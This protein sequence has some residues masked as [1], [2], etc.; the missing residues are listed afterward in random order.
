LEQVFVVYPLGAFQDPT[1]KSQIPRPG[2]VQGSKFKV[3]NS[4]MASGSWQLAK[5]NPQ[6]ESRVAIEQADKKCNLSDMSEIRN[7]KSE[8]ENPNTPG[9]DKLSR[10]DFLLHYSNTPSLHHSIQSPLLPISPSPH[11]SLLPN[12]FIAIQHYE[13]NKFLTSPLR[14]YPDKLLAWHNITF[15]DTDG[16][17]LH[18]HLR[19]IDNNSL[20]S[21]LPDSQLA[22]LNEVFLTEAEAQRLFS[23]YPHLVSN[24]KKLLEQCELSFD[25]KAVKN[26]K[27]LP[28]AATTTASCWKNWPWTDWLTVTVRKTRKP[29]PG[30]T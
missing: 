5:G 19:A 4:K 1:P 22:N 11:L 2:E 30:Q 20:L 27:L 17:E 18:R 21:K 3:Q 29:A 26:K 28:A 14:H 23:Q 7:P 13:L 12:E 10:R 25:F 15:A 16:F 24:A 9:F 6:P 8:I